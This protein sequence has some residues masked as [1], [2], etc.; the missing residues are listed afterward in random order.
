MKKLSLILV[1]I[2]VAQLIV[3]CAGGRVV[4]TGDSDEDI[5]WV[6]LELDGGECDY[7]ECFDMVIGDELDL[8]DA[9]PI[10][11]GYV[12]DNWY[13]DDEV[14]EFPYVLEED[15]TFVAKW[16]SENEDETDSDTDSSTAT[17]SKITITFDLMGGTLVNGLEERQATPGNTFRLVPDVTK[18]G[19]TFEGWKNEDGELIEVPFTVPSED[20][21]LYASWISDSDESDTDTES[22]VD[23]SK[24]TDS[25]T[26]PDTSTDTSGG[27][28]PPLLDHDTLKY[29]VKYSKD[30]KKIYY[31]SASF[32][33]PVVT[34]YYND[35]TAALSMTFDDGED[36]AAAQLAHEIMSQYG[37][38]GTLMVNTGNIQ[39]NLSK[40]QELVALGTLD[41]GSHGWSHLDPSTITSDQMEHEIKDS[42]DFLQ[43][44]FAA[45]NPITY[46]T[47][48]SHLTEAYKQYL[49][50]VG[51][52]A[53]RLE[54][55]GTMISPSTEN[56]DL[57]RLYAKRLDKG[58]PEQNVR[59]TVSD[60]LANGK[61]FI[62]LY[63]NVRDRHS[64]D[65]TEEDFRAHCKWLYD[66]YK[67]TVWFASYDDVVKYIAQRQTA[68]IE[69]TACDKESMTFFAKVDKNYGQEMTLKFYLPFFIDSAYAVAGGEEY[70]L[71]LEKGSNVRIAYINMVVPEEGVE[72]KIY[73]GGNDRYYNNCTHDYQ[74]DSVVN[75]TADT[76]GY[77]LMK[78]QKEGCGN[79][80]KSLFTDKSTENG[81]AP[82]G[83][84]F[85][86]EELSS[87]ELTPYYNNY[88]A[89]ITFTVDD[90]YDGNTATN[91]AEVMEK[92]GMRC[93]AMLNP[94][95]L[96]S[97]DTLDKWKKAFDG[98]Y[99]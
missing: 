17:T 90:G 51:F 95:F 42:Y 81:G 77:T 79:T 25:S 94:V 70:Y 32:K 15:V 87:P 16:I 58:N 55:G 47:P 74:V 45:A 56:P 28:V 1:L 2:L 54:V 88:D 33:I 86:G 68:T 11:D 59:I 65:I 4:T 85:N 37:F 69:Y 72:I 76:F 73:L 22:D 30:G 84:T 48:L 53:N 41:I 67:D 20:I 99:L 38:K 6:T 19:Y 97:T 13:V 78:C 83:V 89:A 9:N 27:Y 5:V 98:G 96:S 36:I 43:E 75:P 46:A 66:N 82:Q 10:K 91:V 61:W 7:S 14:A 52:I 63:H 39:G 57:Y 64:T 92:Y 8:S 80:Y 50:D 24:D 34:E 44:H 49:I 12:F 40:W 29:E 3:G 93:T 31:G 26:E 71:T 18:D 35:L 62:E 23:S 21:T 60:A